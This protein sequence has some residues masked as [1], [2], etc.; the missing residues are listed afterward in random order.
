MKKERFNYLEF[1]REYAQLCRMSVYERVNALAEQQT[2]R[3]RRS[4][5]GWWR[6]R[7]MWDDDDP[8]PRPTEAEAFEHILSECPYRPGDRLT[9]AE[10]REEAHFA[11]TVVR[12]MLGEMRHLPRPSGKLRHSK[13]PGARLD[14]RTDDPLKGGGT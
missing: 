2:Q 5:V 14:E 7:A 13:R 8:A 1:R 12:T 11:M 10:R 6:T 4:A 9:R 3:Q